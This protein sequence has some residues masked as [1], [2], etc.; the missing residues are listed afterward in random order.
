MKL[1]PVPFAAF[2]AA[3]LAACQSWQASAP[4]QQHPPPHRGAGASAGSS[5][6]AGSATASGDG[7]PAAMGDHHPMCTLNQRL[8]RARTPEERQSILA[9]AMPGMLP[10]E[11]EQHLLMMQRECQ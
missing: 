10:E 8:E 3:A 5:G 9:E 7:E 2:L 4:A 6:T 1:L 11:R